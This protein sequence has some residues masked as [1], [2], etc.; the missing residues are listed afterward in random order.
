MHEE[1]VS[2]QRLLCRILSVKWCAAVATAEVSAR[3]FITAACSS[4]VLCF[5]L[6]ADRH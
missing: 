5:A 4:E 6:L 3:A 1:L 2:L